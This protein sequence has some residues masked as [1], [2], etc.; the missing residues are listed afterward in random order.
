MNWFKYFGREWRDWGLKTALFNAR[1]LICKKLG[2]FT[3]ANN[4]KP[5]DPEYCEC[6]PTC[7]EPGCM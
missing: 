1:F 7:G 5:G 6:C 4:Y 3:S 2:G